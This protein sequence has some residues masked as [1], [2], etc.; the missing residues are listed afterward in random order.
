ML[1][2][3]VIERGRDG[4]YSIYMDKTGDKLNYLITGTGDTLDNAKNDFMLAYKE[5]KEFF[6]D[7]NKK[8]VEVEFNFVYDV[9]SFLMYY[10][11]IFTLIGLSKVTGIAKGQLSHYVTGKNKPSK[12]NEEKILD[13]FRKLANELSIF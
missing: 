10:S 8:F 11:S 2:N 13:G 7:N 5:M 9:Q 4:F 3:A 12:K 6:L 1:V